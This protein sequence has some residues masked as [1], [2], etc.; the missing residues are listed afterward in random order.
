MTC[1]VASPGLL[2]SDS[3]ETG[4]VKRSAPKHIQVHNYL[5]GMAGD[6]AAL[7]AAEHLFTWPKRPTV[8]SITKWLHTHHHSD[9]ANFNQTDLL[10]VT[11][12]KV[13]VVHGMYCYEAT[14]ADAIG[15]G[16]PFALGYLRGQPDDLKG[17]VEA[18]CFYDPWCAGPVRGPFT[19]D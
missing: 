13:L 4:D 1:V 15:S 18:A 10:I 3:R 8:K 7:T 16:A 17:A 9:K 6:C 11:K 14:A 12:R 5:V 19:V 2:Y